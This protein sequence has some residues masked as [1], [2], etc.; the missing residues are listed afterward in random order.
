VIYLAVAAGSVLGAVC[1][2]LT[3]VALQP[4]GAGFPWAT[5]GVNVAG[6]FVIGFY[7]ALIAPGGRLR[8][9]LG[10]RQFV[11][12]GFCGGF[13]TFSAFSLETLELARSGRL[14]TAGLYVGLSLFTWLVAVQLGDAAGRLVNGR[15]G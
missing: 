3:S 13:T 12:A 6:S 1:R 4:L 14:D 8:A 2:A 5:L 9:G 7:A 11:M 15:R 10:Q